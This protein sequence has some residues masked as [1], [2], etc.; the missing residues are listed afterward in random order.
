LSNLQYR[1]KIIVIYCISK[2]N[3]LVSDNFIKG[4]NC[5]WNKRGNFSKYTI[6]SSKY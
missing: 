4:D 6:K 3:A 5:F 1:I 2:D